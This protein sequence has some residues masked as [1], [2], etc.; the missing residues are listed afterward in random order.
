MML[1]SESEM[2]REIL[3]GNRETELYYATSKQL[4]IRAFQGEIASV[5]SSE[6]AG[7]SSRV[8]VEGSVGSA[9]TERVNRE[10]MRKAA[11]KARTNA[12][13]PESDPG[14]V[15]YDVASDEEYDA[16]KQDFD[17]VPMERK[18]EAALSLEREALAADERIV[19]VPHAMYGEAYG[20]AA[21]GNSFGVLQ[22]YAYG[23]CY[24]YLYVMASDGEHT[25][26]GGHAEVRTV[27]DE[28][29]FSEIV[30]KAAEKALARLDSSEPDSG[31]YPVV[32]YEEAASSLLGAFIASG[33]SPFYGENIQK[34]RSKLA[35]KIGTRIGADGL[36]VVDDPM[37]GLAPRPFD[38]E[39]V[40]T[41]RLD[42][43][44]EGVFASEIHNLYSATRG[45]TTSTGHGSRG[46]YRGGI[47]TS[48]H[49]PYLPNGAMSLDELIADTGKGVFV[50]EVEGLHAGL[51]PI[52]GD[53]SLSAKGFMIE[54]GARSRP[55]T[56]M[57]VAGNFFEVLSR[58]SGVANDRR[59]LTHEALS[60]PSIRVDELAVSS[61]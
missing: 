55:L 35:G 33:A 47:S 23:Y 12:A 18:R 9:Y 36:T 16:R 34:G 39:G 7:A 60:S 28:L 52:S 10:E 59:E 57:V 19:N 53:F 31:T 17:A 45:G 15:L 30:S 44:R 4:G 38:A 29:P 42:L 43:V 56:N 49:N 46:G 5:S 48:L 3:E 1:K 6:T 20:A 21:L 2:I 32:F 27:F 13:Y 61:S 54:G 37:S 25:E 58:L 51:N 41:R 22:R 8:V 11:G 40:P 14:N 50:T 24:A 26:V